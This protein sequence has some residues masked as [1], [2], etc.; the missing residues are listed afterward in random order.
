M[1]AGRSKARST[2]IAARGVTI[3]STGMSWSWRGQVLAHDLDRVDGGGDDRLVRDPAGLGQQRVLEVVVAAALADPGALEVDRDRAAEDQVD[4]RHLLEVDHLAVAQRSL[5][6]RRLA[7][8]LAVESRFGS[9]SR[10]GWSARSRGTAITSVLPCSSASRRAWVWGASGIGLDRLGAS[11]RPD[12][13][14]AGRRR[15]G[16]WRSSGCGPA[17][18]GSGTRLPAPSQSRSSGEWRPSISRRPS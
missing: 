7:Q 17:R 15:P 8:L 16:R 10:K 12:A 11:S 13:C 4:L 1:P 5:D 3:R 9:S 14:R 6:R 18:P 2:S